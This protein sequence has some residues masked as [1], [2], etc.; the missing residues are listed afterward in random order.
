M[1]N[2]ISRAEIEELCDE[3]IIEYSKHFETVDHYV[4]I[5]DF[6]KRYLKLIVVYENIAEEDIDRIAFTGDG[7]RSLRVSKG[8]TIKE[9]VYP[10]NTIVMDKFLLNPSENN[11]R[12]FILSH[13]TG[14]VIANRINPDSPACFH[15]CTDRERKRYTLQDLKER[16]SIGEWQANT[17]GASLLM[18]RSIIKNALK[19]FNGGRRLPIYGE[20]IFHPREKAILDKMAKSLQVSHTALVIRLKD[21]DMLTKHDVSKYIRKELGFGGDI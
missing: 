13:E 1:I 3:L 9:I 14:H 7:K 21:L 16:Y 11:R 19:C 6:A 17:I 2:F 15:H 4:D 5:D 8:G 18:P 10:R 12:R 20:S